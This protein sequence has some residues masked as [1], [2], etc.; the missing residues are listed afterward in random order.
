MSDFYS[1][2]DEYISEEVDTAVKA[3]RFGEFPERIRKIGVYLL[4]VLAVFLP[5]WFMPWQTG[6]HLG[7]EITFGIL[8]IAAFAAWLLS[9][10]T[11]GEIRWVHSPAVY[12]S[13]AF[14]AVFGMSTILSRGPLYSALYS[15]S[16]GEKFSVLV[17]GVVLFLLVGG[18]L[19][20]KEEAGN[21]FFLLTIAGAVSAAINLIQILFGVSVYEAFVSFDLGGNFNAIG[22]LNGL[23][24]LYAA[25][26]AMGIGLLCV[27]IPLRPWARYLVW[28]SLVVFFANIFLINFRTSWIM[29][30]GTGIVLFGLMFRKA[31][32]DRSSAA[33]FLT[34]SLIAIAVI[35]IFVRV[36][37]ID[38][39]APSEVSPSMNST[40]S[41]GRAV[42]KEGTKGIFIGSGPATFGLDWDLYKPSSINQNALFWNVR[43]NQGYSLVATLVPTT[44]ILGI[45]AF[46]GFLGVLLYLFL[47]H[48]L[49]S[50][51]G[52]ALSA[53]VFSGFV[54]AMV[55]LFIYPA[56]LTLVLLFFLG[57][58][59]LAMLFAE[60]NEKGAGE[61]EEA[62]YRLISTRIIRMET[63][64][65]M[66]FSSLIMI[67]FL[68]LSV[69]ALYGEFARMRS[70]FLQHSAIRYFGEGQF[71]RGIERI[72]R[73]ADIEPSNYRVRQELVQARMQKVSE[74]IRRANAGE[75]V[76]ETFQTE[77]ARADAD[78]QRLVQLF[79]SEASVW[80]TRGALYELLIPFIPGAEKIS[81]E[82]YK[83]ASTV[84]PLNPTIY[85]DWGRA[86]LT[87]IDR[88]RLLSAQA[89]GDEKAQLDLLRTQSLTE[90][91]FILDKSIELK[92]DYATG[93]FLLS[94]A[95]L[96]RNDINAAIQSTE[97]TKLAAPFDI[98]V[99]FQLGLLYYQNSDF[100]RAQAEFERAVLLNQD[101]SN[102]RYFLGLIY[103]IKGDSQSALEQFRKV[104]GLNPDNEEVKMIIT[105]LEGGKTAL[106]GI[107]PPATPPQNRKETPVQK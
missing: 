43:F 87:Y 31:Y 44:G 1:T 20:Q 18:L 77:V 100:D 98:G 11:K 2:S 60:E 30:L 95:A 33:L 65:T 84:D 4:Y 83:A 26:F 50:E 38:L 10:L 79:P 99:A 88:L 104:A 22:T 68:S 56:N 64:W 14:V 103:S 17:L 45:L 69:A 81:F 32:S 71:D 97:R 7:R 42:F 23:A 48:A 41:V 35:M 55:S 24:L 89:R 36:P 47:R 57:G 52:S 39:K 40:L 75:N 8:I 15:E 54:A 66:F 93:H 5:L 25:L 92:P 28:I 37:I 107:V 51:N 62:G 3:E 34:L 85:G 106:D 86:A 59:L 78:A 72:A 67:S 96:R 9:S 73:A 27:S 6:L 12:A 90:V 61:G 46:L 53:G 13:L 19:R 80:R 21:L 49:S 16:T 74:V 91:G 29:L 63:P 105:N 70:G 82:S 94:Q 102:A 58:G 76:Q 101:Y